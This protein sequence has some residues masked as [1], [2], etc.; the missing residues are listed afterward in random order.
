VVPK[1]MIMGRGHHRWAGGLRWIHN[2]DEALSLPAEYQN[3]M[4]TWLHKKILVCSKSGCWL[5]CG[6]KD[7]GG[8]GQIN[9]KGTTARAHR[10]SYV[11]YRGAV[12]GSVVMHSCD[13]PACVNPSHLSLGT[14]LDNI[15]D[16]VTKGKFA[17]NGKRLLGRNHPNYKH[18]RYSQYDKPGL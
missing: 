10:L 16:A 4:K 18:G 9:L 5:W 7:R 8:Y 13:T 11:L 12:G 6:V 15:A 17:G 2:V 3:D 1:G 14:N